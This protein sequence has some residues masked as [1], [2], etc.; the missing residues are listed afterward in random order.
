MRLRLTPV[1]TILIALAFGSQAPLS[2]TAVEIPQAVVDQV[3]AQG[4]ARVIVGV[5]AAFVPEGDLAAP[6]AVTEQRDTIRTTLDTV[7]TLAAQAGVSIETRFDYIPYFVARVD[8]AAL[9][10]LA[11]IPGVQSIEGEVYDRPTLAQSVPL[12]NA[13]AAWSA[14]ATGAGWNVVVMDT[15]V[16]SGHPFLAGKVLAEACFSAASGATSLCP[17]GVSPRVGPGTG[18]NCAGIDACSHGTHVAG[19]AAGANGPGGM[20]GVAPG[21]GIISIQVFSRFTDPLVCGTTIPCVASSSIDQ[22]AALNA[23]FGATGAGNA[24]RIASINMS[25]GGQPQPGFCDA[26]N[27]ARKAAIDNLLSIGIPTVIAS[28]NNGAVN[29]VSAPACISTAVSVGSTTKTD[30]MSNFGNRLPG[31]IKLMAPGGDGTFAGAI[32]SSVPGGGFERQQGT[33]MAAPHVAGAWAVLKQAAPTAGVV[34]ILSALQSTGVPIN[35][36]PSG[37]VY[38]RINVNAARQTLLAAIGAPGPPQGLTATVGAPGNRVTFNWAPPATGAAPTHYRLL[39]SLAPGGAPIASFNIPP[40]TTSVPVG[41]VPP[42]TYFVRMV[43]VNG[44]GTSAF[45]NEV[46]V[47]I[48]PPGAPALNPASLSGRNV[49]LSWSPSAGIVVGY[50]VVASL[51]PGGAPIASIPVAATTVTV[52]APP[53]TF[54]V[55]VHGINA[56]GASVASNEIT[57]VVP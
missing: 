29:G 42:G 24:L 23:V 49:T 54:Y 8:Q 9:T 7:T 3:S 51:A 50:R 20:N 6:A 30:L 19:I 14:G 40:T 17:G 41:G 26:T 36:P 39:A 31:V 43:A 57:V 34:S 22:T 35:D 46:A 27:A 45:S 48:V 18:Q 16:S 47:S 56:V 15:G 38:P 12:V 21:A 5:R 53:G 25:L 55:R 52:P 33:S 2:Q 4:T 32:N 13:P 37:G 11:S 1:L 28:G 44:G 10:A